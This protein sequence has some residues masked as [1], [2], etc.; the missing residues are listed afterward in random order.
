MGNISF[1]TGRRTGGA[2]EQRRPYVAQDAIR[3]WIGALERIARS[4]SAVLSESHRR[5]LFRASQIP[6]HIVSVDEVGARE[7]IPCI[8]QFSWCVV[9]ELRWAQAQT[10]P[11]L[12]KS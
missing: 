2:D 3:G 11:A 8:W 10:T 1:D 6:G 7:A 4:P 12:P 5:S 9:A